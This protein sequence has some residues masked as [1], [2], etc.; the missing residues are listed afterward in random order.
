[1]SGG[2][3]CKG[4][5]GL[6]LSIATE[7]L[8]DVYVIPRIPKTRVFGI[9]GI[10]MRRIDTQ[11]RPNHRN[12]KDIAGESPSVDDRLLALFVTTRSGDTHPPNMVHH[13]LWA[14]G[15]LLPFQTSELVWEECAKASEIPNCRQR[16]GFA[17]CLLVLV[18][19][20]VGVCSDTGVSR[21]L[22]STEHST[23][24]SGFRV[25]GP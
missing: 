18:N 3:D 2:T 4:C 11:K 24:A 7:R 14:N 25:V 5:M 13:T 8:K 23:R 20:S 22:P 15:P 21:R 9:F 17:T 1:M 19:A 6:G 10:V 12:H 16:G